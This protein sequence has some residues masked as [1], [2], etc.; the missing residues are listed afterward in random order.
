MVKTVFCG[1]T[2]DFRRLYRVLRG[3]PALRMVAM[4]ALDVADTKAFHCRVVL[5]RY[6]I[7]RMDASDR[8]VAQLADLR[9]FSRA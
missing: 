3:N 7:E 4:K 9:A 6:V 8:S 2:S 5:F 1:G